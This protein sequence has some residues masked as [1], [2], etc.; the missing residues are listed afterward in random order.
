MFAYAYAMAMAM[1]ACIKV[2]ILNFILEKYMI[3]S[4]MIILLMKSCQDEC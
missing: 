3:A 2:S 1:I 4:T